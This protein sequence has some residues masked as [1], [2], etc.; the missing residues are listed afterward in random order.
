[1]ATTTAYDPGFTQRYAGSIRRIINKNGAFNVKR[2][3]VNW[4]DVHPYLY[5]IN[6]SWP[7][8]FGDM[9]GG[10]L[11][12]NI[13][14]ASLYWMVGTENLHGAEA[15]TAFGRFLNAF[16]FSAHTL[17]TVGY[18]NIFP[19]GIPAN[20]VAAAEALCG[21][22]AFA[23]ATGLL[24]GRFSRPAA[25]IG[26]SD[27]ALVTPYKDGKSMKFRI[28][29]RRSN[30]L[31]EVEAR[32]LLVTVESVEGRPVRRF[33]PL[34][35]ER[36]GVLFLPLTWTIVH[37]ITPDSPLYNK[38]PEQLAA[39]ETELLVLVKGFDDTFYQI[40]HTR[41]SYR[42]DEIVWDARF[43]PAFF[44]DQSGDMVL[45][46]GLLDKYKENAKPA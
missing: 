30:N 9:V 16:F 28:A 6:T 20:T 44:V 31:M 35:L 37:A 12:L 46:M 42:H 36:P 41:Y 22:M 29:N 23:L 43:E 27:R 5:M 40:L 38:T 18:G 1:M 2:H 26:F 7:R 39:E 21:L 33:L 19:K 4:H 45:E 32:L 14:F 11:V 13:V 34:E 8:F 17:T 3:G 10:Y 15:P 24:F 25:R